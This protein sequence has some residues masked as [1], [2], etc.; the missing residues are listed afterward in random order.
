MPQTIKE[1]LAAGKANNETMPSLNACA[2]ALRVNYPKIESGTFFK[3]LGTGKRAWKY[4]NDKGK[5]RSWETRSEDER[6]KARALVK[7][8]FDEWAATSD[9]PNA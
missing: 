4:W 9:N 8:V 5:A 6:A 1:R 3:L 2:Q 7:E